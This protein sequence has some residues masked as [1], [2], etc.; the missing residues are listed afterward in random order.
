MN[1]GV[2]MVPRGV[3]ISPNRAPPLVLAR[4]K[5]KVFGL[6]SFSVSFI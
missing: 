5:L 2:R 3:T 4:R 6:L 1:A